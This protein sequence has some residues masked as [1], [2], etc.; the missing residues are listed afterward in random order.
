MSVHGPQVW[1]AFHRSTALAIDVME[2]DFVRTTIVYPEDDMPVYERWMRILEFFPAIRGKHLY[3]DV[4]AVLDDVY[5]NGSGQVVGAA[6]DFLLLRWRFFDMLKANG[7]GR[8]HVNDYEIEAAQVWR[9]K[10]L[11]RLPSVAPE[12]YEV[13]KYIPAEAAAWKTQHRWLQ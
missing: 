7:I 10:L 6:I 4:S 2:S 12:N 3:E 1:A 11:D 9:D 13:G 8:T 5:R